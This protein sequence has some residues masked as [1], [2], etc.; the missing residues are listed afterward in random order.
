MG[1]RRKLNRIREKSF[2]LNIFLISITVL[3]QLDG[4]M[5]LSNVLSNLLSHWR[6]LLHFLLEKP[7]NLLLDLLSFNP[8]DIPSPIPESITVLS[9]FILCGQSPSKIASMPLSRMVDKIRSYPHK[10]LLDQ[11]NPSIG[12][13]CLGILLST[14][15]NI[16]IT[17]PAIIVTS[18]LFQSVII[19]VVVLG[20][21]AFIQ[22]SLD[23]RAAL[24]LED[25]LEVYGFYICAI[26]LVAVLGLLT[27][28]MI[29]EL[30]FP[31]LI[32]A[33]SP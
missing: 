13:A 11:N 30:I 2:T 22:V 1:W 26:I 15:M 12:K 4:L 7:I 18:I 28:S 6:G 23:G 29:L 32:A 24:W 5:A 21:L 19:A 9:L 20:S 10:I 31:Y 17:F 16:A 25:A 33:T 3:A 8:I 27:L 14:T